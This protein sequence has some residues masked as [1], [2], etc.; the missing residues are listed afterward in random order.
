V[1]FRDT[2]SLQ[3]AA[4]GERNRSPKSWGLWMG[5]AVEW[6]ILIAVLA[7]LAVA[8]AIWQE[9]RDARKYGSLPCPCCGREFGPGASTT[10][11]SHTRLAWRCRWESG[12]YLRCKGCGVGFR[13]SR[14]GQ[15]HTEQFEEAAARRTRRC[16]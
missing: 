11:H 3:R 16:T 9:R 12:P 13:Y 1:F 15:L 6:V 8:V 5:G 10:W 4:A 2:L 7:T 14:S